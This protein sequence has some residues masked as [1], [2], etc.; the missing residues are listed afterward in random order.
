[1]HVP[2]TAQQRRARRD[3]AHHHGEGE[4]HDQSRVERTGDEVREEP[5]TGDLAGL[6]GRQLGQRLRAEQPLH[7]AGRRH[8]RGMRRAGSFE[9]TVLIDKLP[10][11][12][13]AQLIA[14]LPAPRHL[15]ELAEDAKTTVRAPARPA[16]T[17]RRGTTLTR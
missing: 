8:L 2:A 7:R 5:R 4:D 3:Q 15:L 16:N 12:E 6:R 11:P 13:A 17:A 1:V 10:E 14:A 9:F